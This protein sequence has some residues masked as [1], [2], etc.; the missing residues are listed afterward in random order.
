MTNSLTPLKKC[1]LLLCEGDFRVF[2][3]ICAE[4]HDDGVATGGIQ[5]FSNP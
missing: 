2:V 3:K 1:A 4:S 5:A